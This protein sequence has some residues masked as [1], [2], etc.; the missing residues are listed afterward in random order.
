MLCQTKTVQTDKN[1]CRF[2]SKIRFNVNIYVGIQILRSIGL[3]EGQ[4]IKNLFVSLKNPFT[5]LY[6]LTLQGPYQIDVVAVLV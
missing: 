6:S 5:E 2:E 3:H 1:I 4:L